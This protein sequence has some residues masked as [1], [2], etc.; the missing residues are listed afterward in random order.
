M[1]ANESFR[2]AAVARAHGPDEC[3]V[4]IGYGLLT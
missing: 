2:G 4:R 1:L 3:I